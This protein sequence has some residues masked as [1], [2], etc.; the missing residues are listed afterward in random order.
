[1]DPMAAEIHQN[2]WSWGKKKKQ[3]G[4]ELPLPGMVFYW[5]LGFPK[6]KPHSAA[7]LESWIYFFLI[8]SVWR[9]QKKGSRLSGPEAGTITIS[10]TATQSSGE[11]AGAESAW[12]TPVGSSHVG[13]SVHGFRATAARKSAR[14]Q[15]NSQSLTVSLT[16]CF[17][18]FFHRQ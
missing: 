1:M 13:P 17:H 8:I 9:V 4:Q 14:N 7:G 6:Q 18:V 5:K 3:R 2:T 11:W 10:D 16:A 15:L 12:E